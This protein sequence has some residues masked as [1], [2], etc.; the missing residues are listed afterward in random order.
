MKEDKKDMHLIVTKEEW[1]DMKMEA[2][3][4]GLTL[5]DYILGCVNE[6][7]IQNDKYQ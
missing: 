3:K 5:K 4:R 7:K 6:I 1:F 2:L